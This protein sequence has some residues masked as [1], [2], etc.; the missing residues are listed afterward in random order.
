MQLVILGKQAECQQF[1]LKMQ[2]KVPIA[3]N[4]GSCV[5]QYAGLLCEAEDKSDEARS[6]LLAANRSTYARQ[7][8]DYMAA[9]ARVHCKERGWQ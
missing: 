7:S 8:K 5:V 6:F 1:H 4:G 3:V 9:L 2:A